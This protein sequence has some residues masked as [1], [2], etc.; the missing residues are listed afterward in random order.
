MEEYL[1]FVVMLIHF[2]SYGFVAWR[3]NRRLTSADA[4]KKISMFVV[5]PRSLANLWRQLFGMKFISSGDPTL[6]GAGIVHILT[7]TSIVVMLLR[8]LLSEAAT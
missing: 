4:S 1:V 7:T 2:L 3:V 6:I 5:G 8:L